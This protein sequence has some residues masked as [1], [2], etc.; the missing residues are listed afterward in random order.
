MCLFDSN[1]E[2]YWHSFGELVKLL[3]FCTSKYL[4]Y[5]LKQLLFTDK[6]C[7]ISKYHSVKCLQ[8]IKELNIKSIWVCILK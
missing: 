5:A 8:F 3:K 6:V 4:E 1:G 7:K 2:K